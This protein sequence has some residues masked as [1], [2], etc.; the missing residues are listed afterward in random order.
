MKT[1]LNHFF[2]TALIVMN[3]YQALA[4][5]DMHRS[6]SNE[7]RAQALYARMFS[8][9]GQLRNFSES[10]ARQFALDYFELQTAYIEKR[11]SEKTGSVD[12]TWLATYEEHIFAAAGVIVGGVGLINKLDAQNKVYCKAHPMTCGINMTGVISS[13]LQNIMGTPKRAF[14]HGF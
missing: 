12:Q 3:S 14:V 5:Q 13:T 2:V 10:E 8:E 6:T 4:Q 11:R 7:V 1:K 9:N